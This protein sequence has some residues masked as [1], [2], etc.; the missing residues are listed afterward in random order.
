MNK[1]SCIKIL[2][3]LILGVN[4]YASED[5]VLILVEKSS[6]NSAPQF[7]DSLDIMF[8]NP[9][10]WIREGLRTAAKSAGDDLDGYAL[11][12]R[13]SSNGTCEVIKSKGPDQNRI[14]G[15][16][17]YIDT[18]TF[19]PLADFLPLPTTLL[20]FWSK[21]SCYIERLLKTSELKEKTSR[22]FVRKWNGF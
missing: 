15:M 18:M 12:I 17:S 1:I 9:L 22:L 2:V 4:S 10:E 13:C 21:K 16:I 6:Y 14:S 3:L 20:I 8:N 11:L 7:P 5:S 19:V